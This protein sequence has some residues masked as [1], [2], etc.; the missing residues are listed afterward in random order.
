MDKRFNSVTT[1][2]EPSGT[3]SRVSQTT[4][5]QVSGHLPAGKP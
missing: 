1:G 5:I 3:A 2:H 4:G